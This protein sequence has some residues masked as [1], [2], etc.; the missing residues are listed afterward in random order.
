MGCRLTTDEQ[1]NLFHIY[2]LKKMSIEIRQDCGKLCMSLDNV[3]LNFTTKFYAII[4][5]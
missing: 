3:G 5:I 1:A 4:S 2:K